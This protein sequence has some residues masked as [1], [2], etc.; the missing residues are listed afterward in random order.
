VIWVLGGLIVL[1]CALSYW[2]RRMQGGP[3]YDGLTV[4]HY[5]EDYD[6][7]QEKREREHDPYRGGA[8]EGGD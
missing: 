7:I 4:D 6:A 5:D 2:A 3:S 1:I 8:D